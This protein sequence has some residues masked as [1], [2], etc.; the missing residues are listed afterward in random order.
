MEGKEQTFCRAPLKLT[1]KDLEELVMKRFVA[2][3][4]AFMLAIGIAGCDRKAQTK[5]TEVEKTP[6]GTTTTE[7]DKTVK[8]TGD[9]PPANSSG[10]TVPP[11][12]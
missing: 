1:K 5:V 10:E 2:L 4:T 9:N 6:G 3:S 12:K 7:V 11:S 8:S